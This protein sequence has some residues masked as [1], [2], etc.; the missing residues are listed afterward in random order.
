LVLVAAMSLGPAAAWADEPTAADRATARELA[1]QGQDAL[2]ARKFDLAV[3]RFTR[4]NDLVHAPTLLLGLAHA[5]AGLGKL[6]EAHEMYS[7]IVH[8]GVQPNAPRAFQKAFDD[9]KKEIDAIAPRLAWITINVTGPANPE[10]TIDA[11]SV[12][13]AALGV[14]RAVNP[15]SHEVRA[16]GEGFQAV[17]RTIQVA[18]GASVSVSLE[19]EP[20]GSGAPLPVAS[21]TPVTP[22]AAAVA[23]PSSSN[24]QQ[25]LAYVLLGV[26]GAGLAAG[27]VTGVMA[28][29]KHSK[30][31]D[32]CPGGQCGTDQTSLHNSY[33]TLGLVSDISFAVGVVGVGS[34]LYFLLR[35]PSSNAP[36]QTGV[37]PYVG[38]ASAGV[39]GTFE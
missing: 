1:Q 21:A 25:S 35:K 9:A 37:H 6:V 32:N 38:V 30:L 5:Y 27:T 18:E 28:I 12:P 22:P 23:E 19:L 10:A 24:S 36:A 26:G 20:L 17:K 34:G 8:E 13:S 31:V 7:R 29:Q 16:S 33:K 15:G 14:R 4:A 11:I 3:D 39:T 2:D